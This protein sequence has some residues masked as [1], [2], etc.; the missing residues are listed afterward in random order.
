MKISK[1]VPVLGAAVWAV[2]GGAAQAAT[3]SYSASSFADVRDTNADG[4]VAMNWDK[5]GTGVSAPMSYS[6]TKFDSSLGTLTGVS[7]SYALDSRGSMTF[8]ANSSGA[9][10]TLSASDL[11]RLY[12]ADYSTLTANALVNATSV[13]DNMASSVGDGGDVVAGD[14]TSLN[15]LSFASV[16][17]GTLSST[18]YSFLTGTGSATFMGTASQTNTYSGPNASVNFAGEA[19]GALTVVYTYTPVSTVPE[20]ESYAMLLAGLAAIGVVARRRR[21]S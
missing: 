12:L 10:A 9:V 5:T 11:L 19:K 2:M 13:D 17:S 15:N 3:V 1:V 16:Y 7:F 4:Y 20:P 21:L 8:T 14:A 6:I 18:L